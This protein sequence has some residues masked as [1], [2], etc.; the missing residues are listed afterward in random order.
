MDDVA[1]DI[2]NLAIGYGG[3]GRNTIVASGISTSLHKGEVVALIGRNGA[4]KSTLMRTLSAYQKPLSGEIFYAGQDSGYTSPQELAKK[5]SVVHTG[6]ASLSVTAEEFVSFGRAPYTNFLGRMTKN[7]KVVVERSMKIMGITDLSGRNIAT[8]SDG[9]RQKCMIAK[10]LAQET[11]IMLLD[12]PT[13]FLDFP[14]KVQ[15]FATLTELARKHSKAILVST[16]DMEL[17][18]RF[19]D[20]IWLMHNGRLDTGTVSELSENGSLNAFLDDKRVQYNITDNR[21]EITDLN[22]I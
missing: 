18:L 5:V 11:P 14:S 7:D 22:S 13:A 1:L 2:R 16:H 12:E 9:E 17:S 10:S 8:L 21:I 3:K 6:V 4:G 20:R 19:A 15:L